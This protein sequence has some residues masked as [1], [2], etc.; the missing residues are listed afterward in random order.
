MTFFTLKIIA[1][2][3]MTIDHIGFFFDINS[4]RMIGRI[5]FP[6]FAFLIGNGIKY[7]NNLRRYLLS[8]LG[9]ALFISFFAFLG[10]F[11]LKS[12]ISIAHGRIIF[13]TLFLGAVSCASLKKFNE[14]RDFL[15]LFLIP[16]FP[17]IGF[18]INVD[19]GVLG[20]LLILFL[21][22]SPN[23]FFTFLYISIFSLLT[24]PF[25]INL[26]FFSMF[27]FMPISNYNFKKGRHINK[28]FFYIYYP[29]HFGVIYIFYFLFFI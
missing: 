3:T 25:S 13:Y 7:T 18:L 16:V 26:I 10:T 21:Y 23:K 24:Y 29:L 11:I 9:F 12:S 6:I 19:Y 4:F 8:L 15:Y 17:Y 27:S 2:V 1:I 14:N 22:T 20:I 5:S 28:Y